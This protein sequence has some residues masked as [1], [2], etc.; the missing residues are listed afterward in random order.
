MPLRDNGGRWNERHRRNALLL[1]FLLLI[2]G[3]A[4]IGWS[5]EGFLRRDI[6]ADT[7][8]KLTAIAALKADQIQRWLAD[9]RKSLQAL[10]GSP[11][12]LAT[13][14]EALDPATPEP[15]RR[16]A[17]ARV[18]ARLEGMRQA[19]DYVS[20]LLLDERAQIRLGVGLAEPPADWSALIAAHRTSGIH[21]QD[22]VRAPTADGIGRIELGLFTRLEQTAAAPL[23]LYLRIDPERFLYPLIQ[24][25]PVPS[26]SAETLLIRREGD[27]VVFLNR[28]RH[29]PDTALRLRLSM[30][31][32]TLPAAQVLAGREGIFAGRDY[33]DVP[34]LSVLRPI[35]GT[36]WAMVAKVDREEAYATLVTLRAMAM[37]ALVAFILIG[38]L[39]LWL[40]WHGQRQARRAE[41]LERDLQQQ[42]LAERVDYL[43]RYANDAILLIDAENKVL[44]ANERALSQYGYS[45]QA[46]RQLRLD[47]LRAP[48]ESERLAPLW[49]E[50]PQRDSLV[51]EVL[52]QR[53]NGSVF[54]VEC[55]VRRIARGSTLVYQEII[56]D[57]TARKRTE[58]ALHEQEQ[59]LNDMST[60]AHIGGWRFD[61]ATGQG[62]WTP[63]CARIHDLPED[64]PIDV[65][66]GV[67]YYRGEHRQTIETAVRAASEEG[68]PYDLELELVSAIGQRKWVRII[69]HPVLEQGRVARVFGAIQD[70]TEHKRVEQAL[71]EAHNTREAVLQSMND[72][73]VIATPAGMVIDVNPAALRLH[74]FSRKDEA[75]RIL[76]EYVDVFE[77]RDLAGEEQPPERWPIS[78]AFQGETFTHHELQVRRRDTGQTFIGSYSG[79]P[80]C[81]PQGQLLFGIVT[82]R[83]ITAQKHA[84]EQVRQLAFYDPLTGLA[85]RRLLEERLAVAQAQM[86]RQGTCLA[87][88]V[89]DLDHFKEIND[90][91][92]HATGDALLVE[93]ARRMRDAVRATD[94]VARAGGDEFILVLSDV[95][96]KG[97]AHVAEKLVA[98]LSEPLYL[99][100]QTLSVSC[101]LGITLSTGDGDTAD[102]LITRADTAMYRAK[103][104]GRNRY[105]FFTE[106]MQR[107]AMRVMT[108]EC[109]LRQAIAGGEL[110]LHYQ[111][112]IELTS[113]RPIGLEA[114]VRWTHATRGLLEAYAFVPV[115]ER[116]DLIQALSTWVV[117]AVI[118]QLLAWHRA[119]LPLLPVTLNLSAKQFQHHEWRYALSAQL[120][121]LLAEKRLDPALLE[122]EITENTL[123]EGGNET[124][125]LLRELHILGVRLSLDDFGTGYSCL[126][127]LTSFPVDRLKIDQSFVHTAPE[128]PKQA[129]VI[130]TILA[131]GRHLKLEVIAEGVETEVQLEALRQLGCRQAQGYYFSRPLPP[132]Q[133][134]TWLRRAT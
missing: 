77:V 108:L 121:T 54:P 28:L 16:T 76:A 7:H 25:W 53:Q 81:D 60:M 87:L 31:Q 90:A 56:R 23:W 61:P 123:L 99:E 15:A 92:G 12:F 32:T 134:E 84:E 39:A 43:S 75:L 124:H 18:T 52:H 51:Y 9:R 131:L 102:A 96:P 47:D 14:E 85:N 64:A 65:A 105:Q 45:R 104:A 42:R 126:R 115:A 57:I 30:Q 101:S 6:R 17:E 10:S 91:L 112:Q 83:D 89:L 125:A 59:M 63:E 1:I 38:A 113:N 109:Q 97:A 2:L 11:T 49:A 50:L 41:L 24:C 94:T 74:G 79:A 29:R 66:A 78:L 58:E 116:S 37:R 107:E 111:P 122:L 120:R 80:V 55:S 72:G 68:R 34:V 13:L 44:E 48:G 19:N 110:C 132:E 130:E 21:L 117:L 127:T 40:W 118:E 119:G 27:A 100:K 106:E 82:I 70:I 129:A 26:E 46:F 5:A 103:Q 88:M 20:I 22:F 93:V 114:L 133:V 36:P 4:A 35:A 67:G 128:Q 33:R 69:G 71:R 62:S 8:E 73:L 86:K 3:I 98:R 95:E